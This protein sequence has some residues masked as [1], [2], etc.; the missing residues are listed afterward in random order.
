MGNREISSVSLS[1]FNKFFFNHKVELYSRSK[2]P[3]RSRPIADEEENDN[4]NARGKVVRVHSYK[5]RCP[6][7]SRSKSPGGK[8]VEKSI[9][10]KIGIK[11]MRQEVQK[12]VPQKVWLE[13]ARQKIKE[14]VPQKVSFQEGRQK[15][16]EPLPQKVRSQKERQEVEE[17]LP[18]KIRFQKK[19]QEVE[20]PLPQ[21]VCLKE[22]LKEDHE[23]FQ[24]EIRVKEVR[25]V[26]KGRKIAAMAVRRLHIDSSSLTVWGHFYG[27]A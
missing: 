16:K 17:P 10:Q 26:R 15:I 2:M 12:P 22:V 25:K 5:R 9:A 4:N 3:G 27:D 6:S 7:K 21:K 11:E 8:K 13:E 24:K 23:Q 1:F 19:R 14:P 18:Q 20:E